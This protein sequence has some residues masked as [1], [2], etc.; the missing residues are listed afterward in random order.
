MI[1]FIAK[2]QN[3]PIILCS[4]HFDIHKIIKMD[5]LTISCFNS[6]HRNDDAL[7]FHFTVRNPAVPHPVDPCFFKPADI[8]GMMY[9]AHLAIEKGVDLKRMAKETGVNEIRFKKA[10]GA[11]KKFRKNR[12][13]DLLIQLYNAD[14]D[15][16]RG[17][18]S[19]RAALEAFILHV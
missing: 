19:D 1:N 3:D 6:K 16:K 2:F 17:N 8:V 4:C 18:L 9:D 7:F 15:I 12:I 5:H 13:R 10:Y 14:R 11:A